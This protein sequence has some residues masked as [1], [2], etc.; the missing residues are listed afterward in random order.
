[1][2][3][4]FFA[5]PAIVGLVTKAGMFAYTRWS[6]VHNALTRC[7]L[8]LLFTLVLYNVFEIGLFV[9][10]RD[11]V[12]TPLSESMIRLV[13]SA[14]YVATATFL[15]LALITVIPRKDDRQGLSRLGAVLLYVPPLVLLV[16]F[17]GTS[18]LVTGFVP[19]SY[20]Y[21]RVPGPLYFLFELYISG[22]LIAAFAALLYGAYRQTH[23][24]QRARNKIMLL[25]S[26][27]MIV[28]GVA[29]VVLQRFGLRAFNATA[30]ITVTM[31]ICL[32]FAA[33]ATHARRPFEP[34]FLV[35]WSRL[36]KRK[37]TFYSDVEALS[38]EI[39]NMASVADM[40]QRL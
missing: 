5:L 10:H 6:G 18:L 8:A 30:T 11:G 7:Y 35:P 38:R 13:V 27:P 31:T 19:M 3:F 34:E 28:L 1:M 23:A 32:A 14:M 36:R 39:K 37:A 21:T 26:L 16:L 4:T 12:T 40:V 25:G 17:W 24:R 9:N 2:T 33:Y 29:I 22:Y 15:H 20:T